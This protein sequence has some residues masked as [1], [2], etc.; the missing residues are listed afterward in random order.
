MA[1]HAPMPAGE[2][3]NCTNETVTGALLGLAGD[4]DAVVSGAV[5]STRTVI[6]PDESVLP[7]RSVVVTRS[8]YEPSTVASGPEVVFHG[9]AVGTH[10]SLVPACRRSNTIVAT[11]EPPSVELLVRAIG[12]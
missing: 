6:E 2:N 7:A 9:A 11:P 3:W 1:A 8:S 10:G 5:R 4:S 12:A